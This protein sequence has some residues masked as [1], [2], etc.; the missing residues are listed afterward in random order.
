M[1]ITAKLQNLKI[2]ARKVRLV[3]DLVRRKSVGEAEAILRFTTKKASLPMLKLL[4][5]AQATAKNTYKLDPK[6]FYIAKLMVNDG[7]MQERVFPRSRGRADKIQKRT[8]HITMV[9]EEKVQ[10]E[11]TSTASKIIKKSK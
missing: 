2:T 9:L 4:Q 3:A 8:A 7:P 11:K 1:S 5:S 6:N 10:S